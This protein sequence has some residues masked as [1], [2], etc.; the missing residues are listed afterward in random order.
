MASLELLHFQMGLKLLVLV[1]TAK[2]VG[3]EIY[4]SF[5]VNEYSKGSE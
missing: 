5:K 4:F 1:S 3:S 2:K